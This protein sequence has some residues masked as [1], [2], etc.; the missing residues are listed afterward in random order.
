MLHE[1]MYV[2]MQHANVYNIY[3]YIFLTITCIHILRGTSD[4]T[5]FR[6]FE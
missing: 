3:V 2:Y 6:P 1:Y 5:Y 4:E